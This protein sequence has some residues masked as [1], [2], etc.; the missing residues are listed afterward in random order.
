MGTRSISAKLQKIEKT[1]KNQTNANAPWLGGVSRT[2]KLV[3]V[4]G[5]LRYAPC[6]MR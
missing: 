1:L 6:P 5:L 4:F 3:Y 2:M